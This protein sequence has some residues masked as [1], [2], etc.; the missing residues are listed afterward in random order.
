MKFKAKPLYTSNTSC[1]VDIFNRTMILL[2]ETDPAAYRFQLATEIFWTTKIQT[3]ATCGFF[4]YI[5]P[6]FYVDACENNSQRVFLH[7]HETKHMWL[8][9]PQ[10]G[11]RFHNRGY[12][13][14][15]VPY[16][17][18]VFNA[19]ADYVINADSV[20]MGAEPIKG[21]LLDSRFTRNDIV[22]E[23][24]MTLIE[25]YLKKQE[26]QESFPPPKGDPGDESDDQPDESDESDPGDDQSTEGQD[27]DD[28]QDGDNT[29]DT[30]DEGDDEQDGEESGAGDDESD[31]DSDDAGEGA[32]DDDDDDES[33]EE[34]EGTSS[35]SDGDDDDSGDPQPLDH[36]GHD[37]HFYPQYDGDPEEVEKQLKED[38]SQI[39][40]E[41]DHAIDSISEHPSYR[42]GAGFQ[43]AGYRHDG[44]LSST[45]IDWFEHL[46][47][48][49]TRT[50]GSGPAN[51]SKIHKR[52]LL[53]T[54][55]ISPTRKSSINLLAITFDISGSVSRSQWDIFRNGFAEIIDL[56]K[57]QEGCI[58]MWTNTEVCGVDRVMSGAELLG[59]ETP[60]GGGNWLKAGNLWLRENGITPD[61]HIAFTDGYTPDED[62]EQ[63]AADGT[64]VVLD[65]TPPNWIRDVINRTGCEC[66]VMNNGSR[67]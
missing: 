11:L 18:R 32:S 39:E 61:I 25:E 50:G 2:R 38:E 5:N 28:E 31:D 44:G 62:Y 54:G 65:E 66:I 34:G 37:D 29:A 58:V 42:M 67:F 12:F 49:C 41:V 16:V 10:R 46:A 40:R 30:S 3:A 59:L 45:K 43:A 55:T 47:N 14:V 7:L 27:G 63:W 51:W 9:H 26:E 60:C 24:Y 35:G 53:M 8:R 57:P 19:A 4:T 36:D 17:H 6:E 1:P 15:G 21:C 52:R 33:D 48:R 22:D 23:V 56:L 13:R 20:A 64:I